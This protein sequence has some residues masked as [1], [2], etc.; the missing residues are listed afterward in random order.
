[1]REARLRYRGVEVV[2]VG[3]GSLPPRPELTLEEYRGRSWYR[4]AQSIFEA[5]QAGQ[6]S[7][8]DEVLGTVLGERYWR[9]DLT[10]E[11]GSTPAIDDASP[12]NLA[13]L[14]RLGKELV[15]GHRADLERLAGR[16]VR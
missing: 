1:M 8:I 9:I 10:L 4:L 12:E 11:D 15:A 5:A 14:E 2:S 3:T 13:V 6:T 16:L 7:V